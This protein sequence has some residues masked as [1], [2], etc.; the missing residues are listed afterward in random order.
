V[1]ALWLAVAAAGWREARDW[2]RPP[3]EAPVETALSADGRFR[4]HWTAS[5]PSAPS[6]VDADGDGLPD[7]IGV[8]FDALAEAD[9]AFAARGYLRATGDDGAGG[10]AALDLYLRPI[11]ANGFAYPLP[12]RAPDGGAACFVELDPSLTGALLA[13]VAQHELH[14]CVQYRYRVNAHPWVYEATATWEQYLLADPALD[15]GLQLLYATRLA[16]AGRPIDSRGDRF[17]YA[18]FLVLKHLEEYRRPA[19]RG[20][21]LWE[22][23]EVERDW[24]AALV[25]VTGEAFGLDLASWF[26]EHAVWNGFACARDDGAHYLAEPAGCAAPAS[27][28]VAEVA[29]GEPFAVTLGD[30][31]TA[32][33]A[34]VDAEGVG[35]AVRVDCGPAGEG[36]LTASIL[37]LDRDGAAREHVRTEALAGGFTARTVGALPP[38]GGALLVFTASGGPVAATCTA[39]RVEAPAPATCGGGGGGGAW[40]GLL[41]AAGARRRAQRGRQTRKAASQA[42][43]TLPPAGTVIVAASRGPS[44]KSASTA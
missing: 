44:P 12:G 1:I 3:L 43:V 8:V 37:V 34:Q 26:H 20:P 24:A 38:Q 40:L 33:Y 42:R 29:L 13:S 28:P 2:E 35:G 14:H 31:W 5:G 9:D 16:G 30:A 27:V 11:D 36:A 32:A 39:S 25:A 7:A 6:P 23:L 10:D 22:A 17:E 21:A 41:V 15:V 4:A 19:T 18:G